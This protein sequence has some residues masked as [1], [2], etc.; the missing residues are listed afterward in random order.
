MEQL[1]NLKKKKTIDDFMNMK[2]NL[3]DKDKT[4]LLLHSLAKSLDHFKDTMFYGKEC[5]ITLDEVELA[6]KT[7]M[8]YPVLR[9]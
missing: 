2:V 4:L 9:T 6:H 5:I 7:K 8:R 3:E 1:K